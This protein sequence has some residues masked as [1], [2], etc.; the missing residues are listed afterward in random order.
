[1]NPAAYTQMFECEDNHWWYVGMQTIVSTLLQSHIRWQAT[2]P[3]VLDVGCGTGATLAH[4]D[5]YTRATGIDLFPEALQF[6]QRRGFLRLSRATVEA[7]PFRENTF[8]LVTCFDVLSQR[9]ITD[10]TQAIAEIAQVLKPGGWV[11]VREPAYNFLCGSSHDRAVDVNRRYTSGQLQRKLQA[12]GLH[13]HRATYANTLLFPV[14]AVKRLVEPWL[15]LGSAMA[16]DP[17][18][19]FQGWHHLLVRILR[20]E[21]GLLKWLDLPFGLSLIIL[22]KK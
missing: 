17:D 21:A 12:A 7:L 9:P 4:F 13:V 20:L 19:S 8:D 2:V 11:V 18:L 1:M 22:A 15:R 6:C 16:S 5:Q 14:A 3:Q 10:D